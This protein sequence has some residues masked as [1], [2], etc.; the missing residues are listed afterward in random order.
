M[1]VKKK[2]PVE[3]IGGELMFSLGKNGEKN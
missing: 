3:L 2:I 1:L